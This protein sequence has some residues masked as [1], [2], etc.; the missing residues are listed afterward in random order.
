[1]YQQ[2]R[3]L[4]NVQ[5]AGNGLLNLFLSILLMP[6]VP[7][8]IIIGMFDFPLMRLKPVPIVI[9]EGGDFQGG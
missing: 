2:I 4:S 6:I 1:M 8:V 9:Q 5:G 3:L 7:A